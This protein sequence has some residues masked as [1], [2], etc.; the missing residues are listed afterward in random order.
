MKAKLRSSRPSDNEASIDRAPVAVKY[1]V[2]PFDTNHSAVHP[3]TG[4][5]SEKKH[6]GK[7]E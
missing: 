7:L 2:R 1:Q 6:V 5:P 4:I 3:I